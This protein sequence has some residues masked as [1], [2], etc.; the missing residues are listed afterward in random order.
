[1]LI[2]SKAVG[3][4][5]APPGIV[6][7]LA[8]IGLLLRNRWHHLG[9]SLMWTSVVILTVMSLPITGYFLLDTLEEPIVPLKNPAEAV[10]VHADAI[11]VLG[12]G[13]DR[14][15]P[16][17]GGDTVGA[18]TLERLRYAARLQRTTKLPL[19]V[20]G[21]SVFGDGI[22]EAELMQ[23]A[24]ARDLDVTATWTEVRSRST[25]ENAL[26]SSAILKAAG[27]K[28]VL[29]V[30]HAWHMPRALW[31]FR[32]TG[33]DAVMAPTGFTGGGKRT[34]LDYLPSSRGLHLTGIA[35]HEHLGLMWYRWH[36]R[37]SKVTQ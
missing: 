32:R 20:S 30:T 28:R 24:L 18:Y 29:L 4:L 23:R 19:L 2:L 8:V 11:V 26:Y 13:R 1:M 17:Y 36:S 9:A 34:L 27:K 15:E 12:G 37:I 21:G 35:L 16:Q 22:P 3:I 33:I 10:A 6:V 25:E 31:A 5:L 14:D 7:V